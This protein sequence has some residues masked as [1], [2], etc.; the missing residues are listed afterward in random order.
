[1]GAGQTYDGRLNP[2]GVT[3]SVEALTQKSPQMESS[4]TTNREAVLSATCGRRYTK[5][6]KCFGEIPGTRASIRDPAV[7]RHTHKSL[8]FDNVGMYRLISTKSPFGKVREMLPGY[9][10]CFDGAA[11]EP[12]CNWEYCS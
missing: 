7:R 3:T 11:S 4:V 6:Q 12:S 2:P 8:I 9:E 5:R 10:T 1:M